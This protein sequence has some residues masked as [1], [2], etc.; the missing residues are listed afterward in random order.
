MSKLNKEIRFMWSMT[1]GADPWGEAMGISFNLCDVLTV[2]GEEWAIPDV[3][4]YRP[5]PLL[6]EGDLRENDYQA[7]ELLDMLED[8]TIDADDMAYAVL[9]FHRYLNLCK[10]LGKDY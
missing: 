1:D 9:T 7:N 8:G 2:A 10:H 5:S 6:N 4:Q 3:V